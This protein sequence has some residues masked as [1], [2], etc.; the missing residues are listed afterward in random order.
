M[1]RQIAVDLALNGHDRFALLAAAEA[2]GFTGLGLG[3]TFLHLD[4]R[5]SPARWYYKRSRAVWQT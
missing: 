1:H 4:R 2:L 3:R 5:A